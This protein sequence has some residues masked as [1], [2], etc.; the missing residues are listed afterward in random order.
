M[1][2]QLSCFKP[3]KTQL[4]T[5]QFKIRKPHDLSV[6]LGLVENQPRFQYQEFE[7][8]CSDVFSGAL[9]CYIGEQ[10]NR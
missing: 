5:N 2:S 9:T 8:P 10:S 3:F 1:F 7:S 4:G 6:R